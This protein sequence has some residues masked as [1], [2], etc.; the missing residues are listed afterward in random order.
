MKKNISLNMISAMILQIISIISGLIIPRLIISI[1]GSQTN[2]LISSLNQMMSYVALL[3][4]GLASVMMANLYKPLYD[5]NKE[6]LSSI[7]LTMQSFFKKISFVFL[8]YMVLIAC[9][10]PVIVKTGESWF[11]VFS[12]AIIL[13]TNLFVQY[14]ISISYRLLLNADNKIYITSLIQI[15]VSILNL[16]SVCICIKVFPNIH[17][18]KFIS[19]LIFFIQPICYSKIVKSKYSLNKDVKKDEKALAQRWDGF[20]INLAFFIHNNTD[21]TILTFFSTLLNVSVYSVYYLVVNGIKS[22]VSSIL[23]GIIPSLGKLIAK[24]NKENL[25]GFFEKYEFFSF[26]ITTIAFTIGGILIVPFVMLY[27]KG[28]NDANYYQPF[29]AVILVASEAVYCMRDPYINI[30]YQAGHF[31][32]ISKYA[33]VEAFL[34]IFISICLV[35]KYGMTGIACGTFIA[36]MYRTV[37]Q[38][39]YAKKNLLK[40]DIKIFIK[41]LLVS[42]QIAFCSAFLCYLIFK[43]AD[44]SITSFII[45]M[46]VSGTIT[47]LIYFIICFVY[48]K[49]ELIELF[50]FIKKRKKEILG[51]S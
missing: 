33:Y 16:I 32:Q 13:G 27:T 28:I 21:I 50:G 24:G 17:F 4:G 29:F 26:S 47:L 49:K 12:L 22:I 45:R 7:V 30:A 51:G 42:I 31:K 44:Y 19:L 40:R 8:I 11:F 39:I 2:G 9:L 18:I 46:I 1:F 25:S 15:I 37:S 38:V 14:N 6:K 48:Y 34:N 10:Y 36:M 3:E 20:G 43:N 23:S 5:N 41:Y 35:F